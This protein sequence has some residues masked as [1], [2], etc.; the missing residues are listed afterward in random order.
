MLVTI[1]FLGCGNAPETTSEGQVSIKLPSG[2]YVG[3]KPPGVSPQLFAPDFICTGMYERDVAMTP[4]GKEFYFGLIS[5]DIVTIVMTKRENGV[6]TKPEIV[7]FCNEP[8]IYNLEPHITPDGKRMLFLSTRPKEG[9]E[10]Q[11]GWAYQDIWA[12]D[13]TGNGWGE[14][15]NLGT[16]VNSDAP[17]FYPSTTND[18]TIYFTR[19]VREGGNRR[20]LIFR[21]RM[22]DG[23]YIEPEAL[24]VQVNPGDQQYNAFIDPDERY[25]IVCIA[26]RD[27]SIGRGDYYVC[28]RNED[29]SWVGPINMGEQVNTPGNTAPSPYVSPDG[30]YFFF[31]SNRKVPDETTTVTLS[32]EKILRTSTFPQNGNADI[33][34]MEASFI[35]SLRP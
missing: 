5:G 19:E 11:A 35:E 3:Q 31:A 17:E 28:F 13:R 18:G 30:K 8:G 15:Y 6:W 33:Y 9:Q 21:A 1:L 12:V 16:P 29:D 22:V 32:Y 26:G 14:P 24:P 27:D 10:P 4:D 25:L 20:S 7:P 2:D 34:W 23:K